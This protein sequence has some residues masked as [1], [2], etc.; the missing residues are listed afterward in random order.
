[1]KRLTISISG[2]LLL[3]ML[4]AGCAKTARY[5]PEELRG[6]PPEIQEHIK[7]GEVVIGMTPQ[8]VRYAWGSPSAINV[9]PPTEEGKMKEEWIYSKMGLY[10]DKRLLFI[11]GKLV[12]IF[13]APKPSGK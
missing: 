11:D 1:M 7:S 9:L 3:I 5:S 8:Q 12:D 13:P 2:L 6:F 4:T 10:L